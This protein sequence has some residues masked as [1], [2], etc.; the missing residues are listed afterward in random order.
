MAKAKTKA[1]PAKSGKKKTA[2]S[3]LEKRV[4]R[5]EAVVSILEKQLGI[6][7]DRDGVVGGFAKIS[8]ILVMTVM[9]VFLLMASV[10][11]V[12]AV[13]PKTPAGVAPD[14]EYWETAAVS[15]NGTI[16]T[17]TDLIVNGTAKVGA[18][19]TTGT[20]TGV[21]SGSGTGATNGGA[22]AV[23][24]AN[25][26]VGNLRKAVIT[27]SGAAIPV[28][29]GGPVTNSAGGIKIYDFPEGRISVEGV[30]VDGFTCATNPQVTATGLVSYALGTAV[31][32]GSAMTT[33]EVDL[34]PTT[35][36]AQV[37]GIVNQALAAEAQFDGTSTAKDMYFNILHSPDI[38]GPVTSLVSAVITLHYINLGDY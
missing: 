23:S 16:V 26:D 17:E 22:S 34:C 9:G 30:T 15:N 28:T 25:S 5:L 4:T 37:T 7:L 13:L 27:V 21:S 32:A 24:V 35:A 14:W 11:A 2:G 31:G 36:V 33:T 3:A 20:I 10:V 18:L 8:S 1:T 19:N 29:Y 38:A 6:D 12:H